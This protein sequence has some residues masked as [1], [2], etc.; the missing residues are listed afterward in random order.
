MFW[1]KKINK[2]ERQVTR[3]EIELSKLHKYKVIYKS[4]YFHEPLQEKYFFDKQSAV[5]FSKAVS[6]EIKST[7]IQ[8]PL[9]INLKTNKQV[10]IKDEK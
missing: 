6:H 4:P 9:I 3:L 1:N 10:V 5:G 2:L 8:Q 7:S